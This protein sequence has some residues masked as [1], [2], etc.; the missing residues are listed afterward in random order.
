MDEGEL[1]ALHALIEMS[2]EA[3]AQNQRNRVREGA[4][5][6]L[7]TYSLPL[8]ESSLGEFTLVPPEVRRQILAVREQLDLL[9]Q[10]VP[11]ASALHEKTFNPSLD[12]A[13]RE[14]VTANIEST[15][16]VVARR[17]QDIANRITS[18]IS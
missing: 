15:Y 4:S 3:L 6:N 13:N 12:P 8:L 1:A 5:L 9:N 16:R 11:I 2:P 18:I 7:K 17:A 10:D 14:I